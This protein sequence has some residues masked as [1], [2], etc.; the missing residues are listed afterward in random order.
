LNQLHV[1]WLLTKN[2]IE[3]ISRFANLPDSVGLLTLRKPCCREGV[4]AKRLRHCS[5]NGTCSCEHTTKKIETTLTPLPA[6]LD[7]LRC[8]LK[9]LSKALL[10][11]DT[12][13]FNLL[14]K[15]IG[16][17]GRTLRTSYID[18]GHEFVALIGQDFA[19]SRSDL[20]H[21]SLVAEDASQA[22]VEF[23][24]R[25]GTL[26]ALRDLIDGRLLRRN[27]RLE[28]RLDVLGYTL[29]CI[30]KTPLQRGCLSCQIL[31]LLVCQP[32]SSLL[33]AHLMQL[34]SDGILLIDEIALQT[35]LLC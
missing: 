33:P 4:A 30:V 9:F 10:D 15:L 28:D 11:L 31:T 3:E 16:K 24:E 27:L 35:T 18:P 34:A 26:R 20:R 6:L 22:S 13:I 17:I 21:P 32:L 2:A 23:V 1:L 5:A 8:I 29:L 14:Y 25:R 7:L 19:L 12:E